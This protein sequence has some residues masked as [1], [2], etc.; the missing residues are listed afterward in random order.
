MSERR[1]LQVLRRRRSETGF[2]GPVV[3]PKAVFTRNILVTFAF[4]C[5]LACSFCMVEDV[6]GRNPG[7]SLQAFQD[8]VA[9]GE[10][11]EE[12]SRVVLSG[13]EVTLDEQLLDY[14]AVARRI[15]GVRH[16][17][18]QTNAMKLG[19]A[20]FVARLVE[21]GVDEF[22]VSVHGGTPK[23]CDDI[24]RVPGSF[25]AIRR[26]LQT[27]ASH[28]VRL[29][30]NTCIVDSN[31]RELPAIVELVSNYKPVGMDFWNLWP[32]LDPTDERGFHAPV[33][34]VRP[35]LLQALD[36]TDELGIR[37]VVK[38]F[39][40]CLL[41]NHG[42]KLDNSQPTVL[43]N[44]DYWTAAPKFSCLYDDVCVH[45][46]EQP[47]A[48]LSHAHVHRLGWEENLLQPA[49]QPAPEPQTPV[50]EPASP[51]LSK[52]ATRVL[53][54]LGLRLGD[55]IGDAT[56][57]DATLVDDVLRLELGS[58][59]G[60]FSLQVSTRS[61]QTKAFRH[62]ARYGVSYVRTNEF[63]ESAAQE[64]ALE[65]VEALKAFEQRSGG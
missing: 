12:V 27:L 46:N 40:R 6:L 2:E 32:R 41:G 37:S 24:T 18:I 7:M 11:L 61:P 13:G 53:D 47:C 65:L 16:V 35:H 15:E 42:H 36:R 4:E 55:A 28:D 29:F 23:T 1:S 48:G 21:A 64:A 50:A 20:R 3:A 8:F 38:W 49:A 43:V 26:G 44:D 30:T 60:K 58:I 5:N 63:N 10:G 56:L 33:G 22:F 59:G 25:Q 57:A 45:G 54:A 31:F 51:T 9:R 14:V 52:E 34:D 39:P 19:S 17:R 62:S